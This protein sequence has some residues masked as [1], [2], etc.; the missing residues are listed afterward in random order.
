MRI[1]LPTAFVTLSSSF[2]LLPRKWSKRRRRLR[3]HGSAG[4]IALP[5]TRCLL[6]SP[7]CCDFDR[8]R[9]KSGYV[10][11]QNKTIAGV[12]GII[13]NWC[14]T[15]GAKMQP[16]SKVRQRSSSSTSDRMMM[17]IYNMREADQGSGEMTRAVVVG[18]RLGPAQVSGPARLHVLDA[19][20]QPTVDLTRAPTRAPNRAPSSYPRPSPTRPLAPNNLP[21]TRPNS[22]H[23]P[24]P[25]A[26]SSPR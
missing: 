6:P 25:S 3:N 13:C 17:M 24:P 19:R 11:S 2:Y 14:R 22:A 20:R 15:Y 5:W 7:D 18:R 8:R 16:W 26:S 10:A 1:F 23:M 4:N 21:P 12:A 9:C